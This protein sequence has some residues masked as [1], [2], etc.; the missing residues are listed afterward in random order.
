MSHISFP[1]GYNRPPSLCARPSS[2]WFWNRREW[3]S[4]DSTAG[5][6]KEGPNM[7]T[8]LVILL[9]VLLVLLVFGGIGYGRRG[10]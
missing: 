6:T 5:F 2:D 9:I 1:G 4:I 10:V 3:L 8:W 7:A